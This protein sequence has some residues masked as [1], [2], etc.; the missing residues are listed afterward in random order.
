MKPAIP[1]SEV[2]YT[3][4]KAI[5]NLGK[6]SP[7]EDIAG[8]VLKLRG[9]SIDMPVLYSALHG[10]ERRG[11]VKEHIGDPIPGELGY[12]PTIYDITELGSRALQSA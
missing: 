4:L 7:G 8:E 6:H 1:V 3:V 9:R 5:I 10:M 2:E 12:R 11:L